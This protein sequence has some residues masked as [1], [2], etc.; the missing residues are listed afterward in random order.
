MGGNTVSA[1]FL[2]RR[3]PNEKAFGTYYNEYSIWV[4]KKKSIAVPDNICVTT[5]ASEAKRLL[6]HGKKVYFEPNFETALDGG[7]SELLE[8]EGFGSISTCFTTDF[9]SVGTFSSQE[10]YMGCLIDTTHP[11]FTDFPTL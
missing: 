2:R 7:L 3:F 11:I 9:W 4:Y 6:L 1:L 8:T 10:G 5:D